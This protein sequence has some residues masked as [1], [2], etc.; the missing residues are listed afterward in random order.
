LLFAA[1]PSIPSSLSHQGMQ[2]TLTTWGNP[3]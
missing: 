1:C 3:L 2:A